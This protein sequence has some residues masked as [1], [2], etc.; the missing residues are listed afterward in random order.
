MKKDNS[1]DDTV[2]ENDLR[3]IFNNKIYPRDWKNNY[4]QRFGIFDNGSMR[5]IL[6]TFF[7]W[8]TANQTTLI[9]SEGTLLIIY[10][11]NYQKQKFIT[12]IKFKI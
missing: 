5:R 7:T 11:T 3:K 9:V 1:K 12:I 6:W 4:Q 8:K 2:T 10:L